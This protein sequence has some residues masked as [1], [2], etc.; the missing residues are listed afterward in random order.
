[1]PGSSK[2]R[3]FTDEQCFDAIR[4]YEQSVSPGEIASSHGYLCW[5]Q[6]DHPEAPTLRTLNV[7]FKSWN[8]AR[9][10]AAPS[11]EKAHLNSRGGNHGIHPRITSEMCS[12]AIQRYAEEHPNERVAYEKYIAWQKGRKE[13]P[14]GRTILRD[15]KGKSWQ[16]IVRLALS[17]E[18]QA[19]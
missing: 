18:E 6:E 7:R 9:L 19:R 14:S 4:R 10:L 15:S 8:N 3:R 5:Q 13:I 12:G 16:E 1:M 2:Q 17:H 11:P